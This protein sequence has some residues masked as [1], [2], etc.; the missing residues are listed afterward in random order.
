MGI[1]SIRFNAMVSIMPQTQCFTRD[2][3][4]RRLGRLASQVPSIQVADTSAKIRRKG[5]PS[6]VRQLK[7][8]RDLIHFAPQVREVNVGGDQCRDID[9]RQHRFLEAKEERCPDQIE[10][11]LCGVDSGR[12]SSGLDHGG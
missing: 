8:R 12:V 1:I 7:V 2:G 10:Y 9:Q 4:L 6:E 11:K 5:Q 3:P